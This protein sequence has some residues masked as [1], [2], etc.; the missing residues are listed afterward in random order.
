MDFS[1][2]SRKN[3]TL[4]RILKAPLN[5]I[6]KS[7]ILPIMQ[8]PLKGKKWIVGSSLHSCWLG[9]Y[10]M[11]KQRRLSQCLKPGDVFYDFGANVGL[12]TLLGAFA[13][14]A[15]GRVYSFEP[16][17]RNVNFLKQHIA[18]N[19]LHNVSVY[20][21]AVAGHNGTTYFQEGSGPA[22]GKLNSDGNLAVRVASMDSLTVEESLPAPNVL[23]IDVEGAEYDLLQGALKWITQHRPSMFLAT[24]GNEVHNQ[25]VMLL[26][27]LDYQI[28]SFE[29]LDGGQELFIYP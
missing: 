24:H 18:L 17:P 5:I 25:C 22:T 13:V 1:S 27:G 26:R 3:K 19:H 11:D 16:F 7:S 4:G 12:Y 14:G 2:I 20:E 6:P 15:G 28:D 8:G 21:M 10:E 29:S 9:S 23:K